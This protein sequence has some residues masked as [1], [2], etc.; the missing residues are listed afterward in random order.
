MKA[1]WQDEV[2]TRATR[3]LFYFLLLQCVTQALAE[4]ECSARTQ[5]S[6]LST[7]QFLLSFSAQASADA[8]IFPTPRNSNRPE[9]RLK[10]QPLPAKCDTLYVW[11][12]ANRFENRPKSALFSLTYLS[13]SD[14]IIYITKEILE[15]RRRPCTDPWK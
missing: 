4:T 10:T 12:I 14:Y 2:S 9:T 5:C 13:F 11:P 1:G 7:S 3:T 15:E 8:L 6:I